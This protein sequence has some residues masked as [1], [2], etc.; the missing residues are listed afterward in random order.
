LSAADEELLRRVL[1]EHPAEEPEGRSGDRS[2][3]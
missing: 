2:P 3:Q 1:D